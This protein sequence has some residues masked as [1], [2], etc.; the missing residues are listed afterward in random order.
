VEHRVDG[1]EGV[2][3]L[4]V[5]RAYNIVLYQLEGRVVVQV[6]YVLVVARQKVVNSGDGVA[7]GKQGLAKMRADEARAAGDYDVQDKCL[8]VLDGRDT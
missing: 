5:E 8:Q 2:D 6:G 1:R 7:L 4:G 3:F